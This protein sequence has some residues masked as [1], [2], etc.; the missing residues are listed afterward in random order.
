NHFKHITTGSGGMILTDDDRLRYHASLF[1]DKCY[2]REE[3][4][5]NPFFLAPNYQMTEMQGAVALA[6][7]ERLED[8]LETRMRL[9]DRLMRHLSRLDGIS[10]QRVPAG[11]T[12]SYFLTLFAIDP[13]RFT[14]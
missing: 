14:A 11:A 12:H 2:Q 1:L 6:Q 13:G 10:L 9:G 3:G 4:I 8:F 7:L 5:R